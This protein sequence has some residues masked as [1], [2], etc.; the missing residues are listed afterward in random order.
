MKIF[1][2][3]HMS[4]IHFKENYSD[5]G[6]ENLI[7]NKRH[8]KENLYKCI[9]VEKEKGLDF[10]LITGD[11]THEGEERDY[12]L[13][14]NLLEEQLGGIPFIA[15]PGNHDRREAFCRGF[16]GVEPKERLDAVYELEGLRIIVMDTGRT[17]NG[18]ITKDQIKW[19]RSVLIKYSQRG[20]ILALHHP[21]IE[22]QDGLPSAQ[23][24]N[25]LYEVIANSDILGIFCGHTHHNYIAQF[26]SKLYFTADSMSYSMTSIND[27]LLFEDYVAY[28][29]MELHDGILS[30]Q[31]KQV[32]PAPAVTAS[33]SSD[34]LSL[35][36]SQ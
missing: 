19:L 8:P 22:N 36:F 34:K 6:F 5:Y 33:F 14:R 24:D 9:A 10:V 11:L 2:F 21:L 12:R 7:A 23:Y 3:I 18:I 29:I 28:N 35:L 31:V 1:R 13:L 30:A 25:E 27:D 15:L 32:I 16:L 20:S 4:D 17:I 26:A